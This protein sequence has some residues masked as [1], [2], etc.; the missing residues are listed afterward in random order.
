MTMNE[1]TRFYFPF[2]PISLAC[3][4]LL[5]ACGGPDHQTP[6]TAAL[7]DD[8]TH[9]P[10]VSPKEETA[11]LT[12]RSSAFEPGARIP[13][14]YSGEGSDTSPALMWEGTPDGTKEF[15]LVCD[16]PDAP[17]AEPWVHWI[18]YGIPAGRGSLPEGS[19]AGN[20][21]GKNS[22]G[23]ISYGGPMPPPGHGTH[24][25]FFR[26]YAL[27]KTLDLKPGATK[28][29]LLSAMKDHI[30]AQGELMG[31]YSR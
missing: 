6:Q 8:T 22:W 5:A 7:R 2:R 3:F 10:I 4:F 11:M 25:Y 16:D 28:K 14:K 31:T 9:Q 21:E 30:L 27:D 23:R 1:E 20:K 12:L 17:T 29:E 15:A 26:L 24:R 18:V 13:K 19:A